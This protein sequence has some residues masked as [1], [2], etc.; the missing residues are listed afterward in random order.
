M[1]HSF[2][3]D[4][5]TEDVLA[6]FERARQA[7][8]EID[9]EACL[10]EVPARQ[11]GRLVA[12]M[13]CI[14]LEHSF[15]HG[16]ASEVSPFIER[17]PQ[18]FQDSRLRHEVAKEHYR[19]CRFF[20]LNVSQNEI[21]ARY[22]V[23]DV[24][25]DELP[26][27]SGDTYAAQVPGDFPSAGAVFCGYP[28][29]AE[30]GRGALA[31]VFLARQPDLAERWVVLKITQRLTTE[32][33]RLASLQHS[34]II[35]VYS[36]HEDRGLFG[37][38]MPYLG[39]VTL[40][41]LLSERGW[42]SDYS[43]KSQA[44]VS[45]L[46]ANRFSTIVSSYRGQVVAQSGSEL[47]SGEC[48]L[49][50]QAIEQPSLDEE[51]LR[52]LLGLSH[53]VDALQNQLVDKDPVPA[54]VS[55]LRQLAEAMAYAHSRGVVHRDLKPENILIAND[56]R[57]VVLDFNLAAAGTN[58]GQE[59]VGGTLPYMSPQQLQSLDQGGHSPQDDVFSLG[60][61]AY[62]LLTGMLP[63]DDSGLDQN[64]L[65]AI[66]ANHSVRPIPCR[67][68]SVGVSSGLNGIVMKCLALDLSERYPS[69]VD[70]YED[71][72]RLCRFQV[73]RH[74]PDRSPTEQL[75]KFAKRNPILTSLTA[76]ILMAS[77]LV[78]G[79]V[80]ALNLAHA[81]NA[82][83]A[84][85][86]KA[87]QLQA[88]IPEVIAMLRSPGGEVEL[89]K[90]GV[91]NATALL[92]EW[93]ETQELGR[94][95]ALRLLPPEDR[96]AFS[97]QLGD[98]MYALAGAHYQLSLLRIDGAEHLTAAM[99]W[100]RLSA[101]YWPELSQAADYRQSRF[102][103]VDLADPSK[104]KGVSVDIAQVEES[105]SLFAKMWY[106]REAGNRH[107]WLDYA[108]RLVAERPTDPS[109]WFSLASARYATGD[110]LRA[111]D[112]FDVSAKLQHNSAMSILWRGITHLQTKEYQLAE[113][114][115]S[116]CLSLRPKWIAPR[117]NRAL[118]LKGLGNFDGAIEELDFIVDSEEV[119]PR[120]YSLRSQLNAARGNRQQALADRT[121]ALA[122][123]ACDAD[124][125]VA[126]GVLKISQ[127]PHEALQDFAQ[128]LSLSPRNVAAQQ[129][130]AHVQAEILHDNA[131]AI[132]SLSELISWG[133]GG[134]AAVASR[135]IIYARAGAIQEALQDAQR[136]AS[137]A[138]TA[139]EMLQLAGIHSLVSP[140]HD[141]DAD[142]HGESQALIWLARA[143]SAD[144]GLTKIAESDPDLVG[145]RGID[146]F[147]TLISSFKR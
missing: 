56:G 19:L 64:D 46:I 62:Q 109:R 144:P 135:G 80:V 18:I 24:D 16:N 123:P 113:A 110:L 15:E 142:L 137:S 29:V 41:N 141:L 6:R 11:H 67:L 91:Q 42:F 48:H 138:P 26:Q 88:A 108:D 22:G 21:A 51:Q 23:P 121:L 127:R 66:A 78:V 111:C 57:P 60:V 129:N 28:L 17:Y 125:W 54:K 87:S 145:L 13:A 38:C 36:I 104:R 103:Q 34:G 3:F 131:A 115:F 89:L 2:E 84:A 100:N 27:G 55:L 71:L 133:G 40:G 39:A 14:D 1:N 143:L 20:G 128:A 44:Q 12:E 86:E 114:D 33:A 45:T 85:S 107:L 96:L 74:A 32:A 93:D 146:R 35:P 59:L 70:L 101:Q 76:V 120:V 75:Y 112:A 8:I 106:A 5:Q 79:L 122:A 126:L 95:A 105:A 47:I 136:V 43:D 116:Q 83:L 53:L 50:S 98:L 124:D 77:V 9:V 90:R 72:D 94:Q 139:L 102:E 31:R 97:I 69:A 117:Y 130:T 58:S 10:A 37:I 4:A 147:E 68:I 52:E 61:I 49:E 92:S 25:W 73:L 99:K 118:A 119:G 30:L 7:S 81:R 63:F 65:L 82:K 132:R 134:T 140:A